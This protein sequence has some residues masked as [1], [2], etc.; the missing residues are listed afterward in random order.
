[1]SRPIDFSSKYPACH[2]GGRG[3]EP[4]RSCQQYQTLSSDR[5]P[6]DG[7]WVSWNFLSFF[8]SFLPRTVTTSTG[9]WIQSRR[10][11]R[12]RVFAI[13]A[14]RSPA[15]ERPPGP[16]ARMSACPAA[17]ARPWSKTSRRRAS[18][19]TPHVRR[20]AT[21]D[22]RHDHRALRL[23]RRRA[24]RG[25]RSRAN[26]LDQNALWALPYCVETVISTRAQRSPRFRFGS[27]T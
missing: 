13:I 26:G 21:F 5:L 24:W 15:A 14:E 9:R 10:F 3:F 18:A 27:L 17:D 2:A 23:G 4:R 12:V 22:Q 8:R 7:T 11:E 19:S 25:G 1:V 20:G 6:G 16:G